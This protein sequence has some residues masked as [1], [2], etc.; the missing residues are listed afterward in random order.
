MKIIATLVVGVQKIELV[1]G[2][3]LGGWILVRTFNKDIEAPTVD[4]KKF[5]TREEA[6]K[7]FNSLEVL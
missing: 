3:A 2:S 7:A 1:E 5:S 4:I 6:V